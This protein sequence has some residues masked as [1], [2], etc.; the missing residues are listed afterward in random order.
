MTIVGAVVTSHRFAFCSRQFQTHEQRVRSGQ[1]CQAMFAQTQGAVSR[2]SGKS[3]VRDTTIRVGAWPP[4]CRVVRCGL[5]RR[6]VLPPTMTAS[7]LARSKYTRWRAT[8]PARRRSICQLR[9]SAG[10]GCVSMAAHLTPRRSG[11]NASLFC[12]PESL[13][14]ST[15]RTAAPW[16]PGAAALRSHADTRRP[17]RRPRGRLLRRRRLHQPEAQHTAERLEQGQH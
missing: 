16:P 8:G 14:I 11:P 15:R 10:G 7:D 4:S 3:S 5:S 12:R 9:H 2:T 1:R 17:R 13:R 6:T